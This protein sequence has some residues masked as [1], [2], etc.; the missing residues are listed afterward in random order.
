M[1][2]EVGGS[3]ADETGYDQSASEGTGP[4][5]TDDEYTAPEGSSPSG[6]HVYCDPLERRAQLPGPHQCERGPQFV[7][8]KHHGRSFRI[9]KYEASHPLA[10]RGLAF[11]CADYGPRPSGFSSP[12]GPAEACSRRGVRPWFNVGADEAATACREAGWR[13]CTPG[14]LSRA[15]RGASQKL[16]TYG[17]H[18]DEDACNVR[19]GYPLDDGAAPSESPAGHYQRCVSAE[20]GYDLTGNLW[21][22]AASRHDDGDRRRTVYQ[23]GGWHHVEGYA[24]S[25]DLRC[26]KRF[27]APQVSDGPYAAPWVGF[28]CCQDLD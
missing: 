14:E 17:N 3:V 6:N 18:F 20:G 5:G 26:A 25:S 7:E 1:D 28:R 27:K 23:G 12:T 10:T 24:R 4:M 8:S 21:E 15:C 19:E 22:W 16:Y 11:P 9:F 13:L 2:T